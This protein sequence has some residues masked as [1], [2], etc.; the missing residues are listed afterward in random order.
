MLSM[1]PRPQQH[2]SSAFLPATYSRFGLPL[3]SS[4]SAPRPLSCYPFFQPNMHMGQPGPS[5]QFP[6]ESSHYGPIFSSYHLPA[7]HYS[8][9]VG[10]SRSEYR[11]RRYSRDY[12]DDRSS[13]DKPK[14][15]TTVQEYESVINHI[16]WELTQNEDDEV[17]EPSDARNE[18]TKSFVKEITA[19]RKHLKTLRRWEYT[20]LGRLIGEKGKYV[21]LSRSTNVCQKMKLS[22]RV[23]R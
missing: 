8:F 2:L 21:C 13:E 7:H 14:S 16:N 18:L 10:V 17:G 12:R 4:S 1:F 23:C 22:L 9:G 5:Y 20:Q 15:A 6:K 19:A 11:V 3:V